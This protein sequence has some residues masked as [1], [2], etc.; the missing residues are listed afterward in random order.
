MANRFGLCDGTQSQ[1]KQLRR[2][3]KQLRDPSSEIE[4]QPSYA[5]NHYRS[6]RP[7]I[8]ILVGICTHLGCSP[9]FRPDVAPDDLGDSWK[10]GFFCACH[11]SRFDL[12]G[13]V[14]ANVPAAKNL[15]VPQHRFADE[16]TIVIGESSD[17]TTV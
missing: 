10:G 8:L 12:A 15:E 4:Q 11:G 16:N 5:R 6:I 13:R 7:D 1:L 9:T 3:N 17:G 2:S 14:Y